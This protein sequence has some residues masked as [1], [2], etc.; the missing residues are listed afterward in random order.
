MENIGKWIEQMKFGKSSLVPPNIGLLLK[1]F[2]TH[3][4][5]SNG[6]WGD[7]KRSIKQACPV[8][9]ACGIS[10]LP[11]FYAGRSG[12]GFMVSQHCAHLNLHVLPSIFL[13]SSALSFL[14]MFAFF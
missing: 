14:G 2:L 3:N 12:T 9:T 10:S 13:H 8:V 7:H 1:H 6:S 5:Q 11:L 4:T